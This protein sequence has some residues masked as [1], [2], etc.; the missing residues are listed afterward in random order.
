M[1]E[2]LEDGT[3]DGDDFTSKPK[4]P[5]RTHWWNVGC[6]PIT[7]D[8]CG[9]YLCVDM[10]P[11]NGGHVGQIIDWWH[12]QGATEVVAH[13]FVEWLS[14]LADDFLAGKYCV[15]SQGDLQYLPHA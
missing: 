4:G 3:F 12:E 1:K 15:N 10:V 9:D 5:I 6:I 8:H 14:N 2:M 11:G 13:S 7:Y